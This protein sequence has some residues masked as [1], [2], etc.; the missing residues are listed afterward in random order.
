MFRKFRIIE[1]QAVGH[2]SCGFFFWGA[3]MRILSW[4]LNGIK[5]CIRRGDFD[6]IRALPLM[7][8]ICFQEIRTQE[9]MKVL[10]RYH[11]IWYPAEQKKYSGTLTLSL[12]KPLDV[13]LGF[14]IMKTLCCSATSPFRTVASIYIPC[15][16]KA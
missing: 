6:Q 16:V 9:R 12:V 3:K 4:N 5:S 2:E 13:K 10:D 1:I 15:S 14:G 7:D 8:V 11:H